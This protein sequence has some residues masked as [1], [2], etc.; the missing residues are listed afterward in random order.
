MLRDVLGRFGRVFKKNVFG[1][2]KTVWGGWGC[3]VPFL[4]A[5]ERF[6]WIWKVLEHFGIIS[7]FLRSFF[8]LFNFSSF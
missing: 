5:L 4:D 6:E 7:T 3:F 2:F 1:R 8:Q